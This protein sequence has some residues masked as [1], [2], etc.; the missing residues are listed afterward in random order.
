LLLLLAQVLPAVLSAA[1]QADAT[2]II[3][4]A[5]GLPSA[6]K[7]S[8][9]GGLFNFGGGASRGAATGSSRAAALADKV[10]L[11]R[12]FVIQAAGLDTDAAADSASTQGL[13]I[14]EAGEEAP[15]SAEVAAA[16]R[17]QDVADVLASLLAGPSLPAGGAV[18]S[19]IG[20]TAEQEEGVISAQLAAA[21]S[22]IAEK[23]AAAAA[24]AAAKEVP[25]APPAGL[26]GIGS[27][28]VGC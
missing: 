24:E 14:T 19:V 21:L 6:K 17:V 8:N 25:A 5:A 3:I 11:Q 27:K 1:A 28:K 9:G 4:T 18:L 20:T 7:S 10:G 12:Y 23:N 15:V 2:A 22:S 26:F 16:V 13:I